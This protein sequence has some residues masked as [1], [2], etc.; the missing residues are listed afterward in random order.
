[1]NGYERIQVAMKGENPDKIPVM[2]HN[3]MIAVKEAGVSMAQFRKNPRNFANIFIC[4]VEKYEF[5]GILV[6]I[7]TAT[8]AGAV[9]VPVDGLES[10][11]KRVVQLVNE[12]G[13]YN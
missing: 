4:S 9:G 6:D 12:F 8:L 1:M 10:R 13:I 3:F 5:D 2:L 11:V 7:D